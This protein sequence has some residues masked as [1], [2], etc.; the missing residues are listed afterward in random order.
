MKMK[1]EATSSEYHEG[2]VIYVLWWCLPQRKCY[3][4][5][6][7]VVIFQ[8][9][10]HIQRHPATRQ[11]QT[12]SDTVHFFFSL[13]SSTDWVLCLGA[14]EHKYNTPWSPSLG[15]WDTQTM[16]PAMEQSIMEALYRM[17]SRRCRLQASPHCRGVTMGQKNHY[18]KN[19]Q[20]MIHSRNTV[21]QG[22][23]CAILSGRSRCLVE[24]DLVRLGSARWLRAAK[25]GWGIGWVWRVPRQNLW[26][27]GKAQVG[28][29]RDI[30]S[31]G[32]SVRVR[33]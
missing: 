33:G 14:G 16:I 1:T 28:M 23:G 21:A 13:F 27:P 9:L 15:C 5:A 25:L 12:P 20:N 4:I 32:A 26:G 3:I 19:H 7:I 24:E 6:G 11:N 30:A 29:G 2:E 22:D 17:E 10:A 18:L 8:M 31:M